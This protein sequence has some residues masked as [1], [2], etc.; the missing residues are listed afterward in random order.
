[1]KCKKHPSYKAVRPPQVDCKECW[2][3][4]N[5]TKEVT[6]YVH[7]GVPVFAIRKLIGLHRH[8]CLCHGCEHFKPNKPEENCLTAQTLFSINQTFNLVTPVYECPKFE[9]KL[10]VEKE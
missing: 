1:M 5:S 7:H 3:M 10:C 4:Y 6:Q 2:E 8:H 9:A